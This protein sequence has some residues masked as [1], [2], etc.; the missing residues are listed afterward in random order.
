[1]SIFVKQVKSG[2]G[3]C[4]KHNKILRALGLRGIGQENT[5]KDN[6]CIRGMVNKVSHLIEY[7]L[8]S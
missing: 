8:E 3:Q 6:N 2:I 5:L 4:E 7:R 1:M